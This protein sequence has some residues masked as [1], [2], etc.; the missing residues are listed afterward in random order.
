MDGKD[1]VW[2]G[3]V[4]S[5]FDWGSCEGSTI[6]PSSDPNEVT[7][8]IRLGTLP[9]SGETGRMPRGSYRAGEE[10]VVRYSEGSSQRGAGSQS[11]PTSLPADMGNSRGRPTPEL[12][13]TRT[14]A[15]QPV[16]KSYKKKR[17]LEASI[18]TGDEP[19]APRSRVRRRTH[20]TQ[21]R[22]KLQKLSALARATEV[23]EATLV[24]LA[25]ESMDSNERS[26]DG[27]ESD[28]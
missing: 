7:R 20:P 26:L 27:E 5:R 24:D 3:T 25:S 4:Q 2:F 8:L 10:I 6:N 23:T 18:A 11:P 28:D 21:P 9:R 15:G 22:A 16:T 12:A 13:P 1:D 19:T 14:A 17:P